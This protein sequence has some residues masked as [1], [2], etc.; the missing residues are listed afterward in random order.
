[1]LINTKN[2]KSLKV[3]QYKDTNKYYIINIVKAWI[4]A[5]NNLFGSES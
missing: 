2:S 4:I 5:R 3:K 1:M